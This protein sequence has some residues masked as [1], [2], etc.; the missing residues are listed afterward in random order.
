MKRTIIGLLAMTAAVPAMAVLPPVIGDPWPVEASNLSKTVKTI[1][2]DVFEGRAP[3]SQGEKKTIDWLIQQYQSLGLEPAGDNGGWTQA[4]PLVHTRLGKPEHLEIA[5]R[6][7]VMPL[8]LDKDIYLTSLRP[9]DKIILNNAP[10]VFV[11]YGVSAPERGWDDFKNVDLKGK[12]AV[13]LINDPDFAAVSGDDAFGKFGGRAMT[14]YG[15]WTYKFEEAARRG[16][17]AALIVHDTQGAGYGWNTVTAPAGEGY[18]IIRGETDKP[19]ALQGWLSQSAAE[20]IF[21]KSGLNFENLKKQ[22]RQKSFRPVTLKNSGFSASLPLTYQNI[23][24]YNVL[25][26]IKGAKRPDETI[27]FG[28]HWDAYGIGAPDSEGRTIRPGAIDD[29]VGVA[30]VLEL[31]RLFKSDQHQPDRSL[32]FASWTAEERGILG[33]SYYAEHPLYPLDKTVANFT[34]DVLQTAGRSNDVL[35][36]GAGQNTLENDLAKVAK[37]ED[38]VVK[39]ELLPERGLFF[40]AD[41]LPFARKGVPVLLMMGMAGAYDLQDGGEAAGEKWLSGYMKCYHQTCDRWTENANF[42]GAAQDVKLLYLMGEDLAFSGRWPQWLPNSEFKTK[43]A[44]K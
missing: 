31:A 21:A 37:G 9:V 11:G 14:Y 41:H 34:I 12:I 3:G 2:S 16:A 6:Q 17:V 32:L 40:R 24:S 8:E 43:R 22:A 27:M 30:A 20:T 28:A 26:R 1:S 39:P 23:T 42:Q 29:G 44:P 4:V 36:I 10:V 5:T 13:F 7:G 38:R 35:L 25:G 19:V 33:S 18:D 15:R